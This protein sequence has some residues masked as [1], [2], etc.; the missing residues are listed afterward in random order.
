MSVAINTACRGAILQHVV[1]NADARTAIVHGDL[2]DRLLEIEDRGALRTIISD[3]AKISRQQAAFQA[4]GIE[5]LPLDVLDMPAPNRTIADLAPC[6]QQSICYTSGTTGHS[7]GVMSSYLHLHT[8]GWHC[9]T[10]VTE[11][12]RYL[13]NLPLFHGGGTLFTT[14]ALARGASI[15]GMSAFSI[16]TFLAEATALGGT[17]CV[18]LGATATAAEV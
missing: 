13:V 3:G 1:T 8:L 15:A 5:L 16:P 6:D 9:T 11:T 18:L 14:G 10:H 4:A 12:D 2:L 7:K 17:E